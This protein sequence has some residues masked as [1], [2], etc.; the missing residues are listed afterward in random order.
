[1]LF[2]DPNRTI[3]FDIDKALDFEGA[4]G[5]YVQYGHARCCSILR[6]YGKKP[7]RNILHKLLSEDS[8]IAL[9][10][11]LAQFNKIV[12]KSAKELKPSILAKYIMKLTQTFNNFYSKHQVIS[13]D[14]EMT[15]ARIFLVWKTKE[16]LGK[17]LELLGITAPDEM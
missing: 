8:E 17:G 9:V 5:P 1:M 16:V 4:T 3:T 11:Q 13:D 12:E 15:K 10:K 7:D 2:Q 14:K 6:K